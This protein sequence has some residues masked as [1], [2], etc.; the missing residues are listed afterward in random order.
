MEL[1]GLGSHEAFEL[2]PFNCAI[3]VATCRLWLSIFFFIS[4]KRRDCLWSRPF[5]SQSLE[6]QWRAT[7]TY[8]LFFFD[9]RHGLKQERGLQSLIGHMAANN[10]A[11]SK[12]N[13]RDN[14][15]VA[16]R[17]LKC[18]VYP[19]WEKTWKFSSFLECFICFVSFRL[20]SIF[21]STL[22]KL[23]VKLQINQSFIP[24]QENTN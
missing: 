2:A 13:F 11:R 12:N 7:T 6:Q 24:K 16:I 23:T 19:L 4:S 10:C 15:F 1:R 18:H 14:N 20:L 17:S 22:P 21:L 8:D 9:T 3:P 5:P